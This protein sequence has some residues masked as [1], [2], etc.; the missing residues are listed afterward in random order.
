MSDQIGK[1]NKTNKAKKENEVSDEAP[2]EEK[3]AYKET[4]QPAGAGYN[5]RLGDGGSGGTPIWLISFTDV[6][7]LMLTFFVMLFAMSDTKSKSLADVMSSLKSELNKYYGRPLSQGQV[8]TINLDRI[9][10]DKALNI[11]YLASIFVRLIQENE[12]L[13]VVSIQVMEDHLIL[14]LPQ[15]LLFAP[16][17]AELSD[18]GARALYALGGALTRMK[19]QVEIV[20]HA[21]PRPVTSENARYDQNWALSLGR[22]LSVSAT[23]QSVGYDQPMILRGLGSGRYQDLPQDMP[24]AQKMDLSRRVDIIIHNHDGRGN[25]L[26]PS[27]F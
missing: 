20:G 19:N 1:D 10:F 16:A 13:D 26:K 4:V 21:D 12:A 22:A 17:R 27:L 3:A 8:D 11:N 6:M 9:N 15:S 5:R 18:D 2:L 23:L 7:A 14:S 24:E 25:R